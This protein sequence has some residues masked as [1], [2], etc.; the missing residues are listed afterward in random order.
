MKV[1][2]IWPP[3]LVSALCT[4]TLRRR[5][6]PS[7]HEDA[8][9]L[10]QHNLDPKPLLWASYGQIYEAGTF[11]FLSIAFDY[12]NA[13]YQPADLIKMDFLLNGKSC[14]GAHHDC[15]QVPYLFRCDRK[16]IVM[17]QPKWAKHHI[18]TFN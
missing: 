10:P 18:E 15:A 14:G 4:V 16:S 11:L 5:V 9:F 17:I 6:M 7:L 1:K 13:G 12:E 3:Q 8:C 2:K